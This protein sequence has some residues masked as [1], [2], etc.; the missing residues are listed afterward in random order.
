MAGMHINRLVHELEQAARTLKGFEDFR[1]PVNHAVVA[2]VWEAANN[3]TDR[4]VTVA[5]RE[6]HGTFYRGRITGTSANGN[7]EVLADDGE[8]VAG[9]TADTFVSIRLEVVP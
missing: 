3:W 8:L 2:A 6:D 1:S 5:I 9:V 7:W 4:I